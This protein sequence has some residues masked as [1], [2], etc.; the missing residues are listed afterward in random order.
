[1][2]NS[3]LLM[4]FA[5]LC[6]AGDLGAVSPAAKVKKGNVSLVL[7]QHKDRALFVNLD[8]V[9]KVIHLFN[10]K[11]LDGWYTYVDSIGVDKDVSSFKVQKG[12]IHIDGPR[13]GYIA[14]KGSFDNYYLKVVF[15]WGDKKYAPR[16]DSKRDSGVL[17]HFGSDVPDKVWPESVE[18]QIQEGDCG[19]FWCVGGTNLDSP[20]RWAQE[21]DQKRVFRSADFENP[22]GEWNTIEILCYGDKAEHY[23]NGHLVNEGSNLSVTRGKILLQLEG[24]EVFYKTVDLI[25]LY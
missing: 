7:Q 16:L 25:Q 19:D 17:Y 24:A 15:K 11:N 3:C 9:F 23:V 8:K 2:K 22:T 21:W 12:A 1:M 10:G 5:L 20:N 4:L 13:M 14:T 18:C 6:M